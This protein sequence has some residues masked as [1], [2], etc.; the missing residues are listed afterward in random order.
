MAKVPDSVLK[1]QATQAKIE[2]IV[3]ESVKEAKKA[4]KANKAEAIANSKKYDEEYQ[5][6]DQ[7]MVDNRR[8]AHKNGGFYVPAE[9]KLALV[10]RIRGI[11][12]VAPKPKKIMQLFRLRQIHNAVFVRMN[13]AT[14]RMLRLIEP[15]VAYGYP[16]RETIKKLIYKRG[17]GKINKQRTPISENAVII[18]GLS[19]KT[20]LKCTADLIHEIVTVGPNFKAA[21]N[22]LWPFKLTAPRGGFS[23]K[24]KMLHYLEGGEAGNRG[25]EINKMVKKMI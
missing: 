24:T 17:F 21:N 13:E 4:K 12:G 1:K 20:G 2:K 6:T 9:P 23:K 19:E 22:F 3:E 5:K 18:D 11:I 15:Y 14:I 25:E 10:I 8:L 7:D 16:S